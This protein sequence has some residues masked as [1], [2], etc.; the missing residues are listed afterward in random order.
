MGV[1]A[2]LGGKGFEDVGRNR[3][4][5]EHLLGLSGGTEVVVI[6]TA[7]A[8]EEPR[9]A[10]EAATAWFAALGASVAPAMVLTR[11]DASDP[12]FAD[13][14]SSA[15]FV[16]LTGDSPLHLR[17]TLKDTPVWQAIV[18]VSERGV[19][20]A[21]GASAAGICDPM[22]DPRGG[23]FGLGLG[24]VRPLAVLHESETWSFDRLHRARQLAKGFTVATLPSGTARVRA[25]G[26][27]GRLEG[28]AGQTIE[29]S[30]EIPG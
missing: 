9:R 20:A 30:G 2:L 25:D 6:P 8:F 4:V 23:A 16:Y 27:W 12:A 1:V 5:T 22:T 11:R 19:L 17:S 14:I 24:L 10:V 15:R 21:A 28:G 13:L 7:D 3:D 29:L 26:V 18:E